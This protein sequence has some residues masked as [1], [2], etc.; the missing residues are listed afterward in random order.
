MDWAPHRGLLYVNLVLLIA[1]PSREVKVGSRAGVEP[2]MNLPEAGP[3]DVRVDLR[4]GD[5]GMPQHEL[6]GTKI[7]P[8]F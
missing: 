1:R 6:H 3:T 2:F 8:V 4:G 5:V 7:C